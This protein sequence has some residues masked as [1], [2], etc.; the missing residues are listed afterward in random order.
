MVFHGSAGK[1]LLILIGEHG[2]VTA[3]VFGSQ[4]YIP[5]RRFPS[6]QY[7]ASLRGLTVSVSPEDSRV[8]HLPTVSCCQHRSNVHG[9]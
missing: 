4:E 2:Y 7:L 8:C 6:V 9:T 1:I 3:A 5:S